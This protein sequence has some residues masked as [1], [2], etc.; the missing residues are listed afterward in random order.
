MADLGTVLGGSGAIGNVV[1]TGK[2]ASGV[3]GSITF[4]SFLAG[5]AEQ[6]E[7]G[8]ASSFVV[9]DVAVNGFVADPQGAVLLEASG[10][11]LG[12]P[13][14]LEVRQ[15]DSPVGGGEALVASRSRASPPGEVVGRARSVASILSGVP[16]DLATDGAAVS[17]ERT[18]DLGLGAALFAERGER[19]SLFRGE[20]AVFPHKTLPVLGRSGRS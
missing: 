12:A 4:S 16:A 20:L 18:S 2:S 17:T 3:V 14:L 15:H 7:V 11:L 19:I 1:F 8:A 9:P 6:L 13:V 5:P 10:D